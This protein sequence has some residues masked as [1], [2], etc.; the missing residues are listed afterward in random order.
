[1]SESHV[2]ASQNSS[3]KQKVNVTDIFNATCHF[4]SED[5]YFQMTMNEPAKVDIR[6]ADFLSASKARKAIMS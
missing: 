1:M 2:K 5:F 6:K 3:P 4:L